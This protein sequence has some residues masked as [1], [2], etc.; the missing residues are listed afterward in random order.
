EATLWLFDTAAVRRAIADGSQVAPI[1]LARISGAINTGTG[2]LGSKGLVMNILWMPDSSGVLFLGR[3]QDNRQ[4]F[5]VGLE[6]R[7]VLSLSPATQDVVVFA[8]GGRRIVYLAGPDAS[9]QDLWD[10]APPSAP[11]I[12]VGTGHSL[13]GLFFPNAW[14]SKRQ[15]PTQFEVWSIDG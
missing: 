12:V 5:R 1:P 15:M 7:K 6:D 9:T 14:K 2:V 3:A 4:L 11:D 13:P 8:I 10:A